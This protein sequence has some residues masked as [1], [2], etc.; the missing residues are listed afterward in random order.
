MREHQQ[1]SGHEHQHGPG[2][3]HRAVRHDGH[4]DYLHD[5][6]LHNR[7]G[8]HVDE[9]MIEVS[10][11][12]PQSC[13][14]GHECRE[15]ASDHRHNGSCGHEQVRHGEHADYLVGDHLHSEHEGHCDLHGRVAV[16]QN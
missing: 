8:D 2:C 5:G 4:D 10:S 7:H 12:N 1:H 13:S 9:H 6:H 11:E 16:A 14:T 3:G 15:H